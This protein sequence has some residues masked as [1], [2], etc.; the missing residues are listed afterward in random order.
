[1]ADGERVALADG[2][3]EQLGAGAAE[4][5]GLLPSALVAALRARSEVRSEVEQTGRGR[6]DGE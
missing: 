5:D 4:R 3:G 6:E 2:R 1:V